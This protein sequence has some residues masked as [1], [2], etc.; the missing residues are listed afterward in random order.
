MTPLVCDPGAAWHYGSGIDWAGLMIEAV[1]GTTLDKYLA[2]NVLDP[3]SMRDTRYEPTPAMNARLAGVS[4]RDADGTLSTLPFQSPPTPEI[5]NGGHGLISTAADYAR[6]LQ[7]LLNRGALAG[8]RVLAAKTVDLMGE[9]HIG[10]LLVTRLETIAPR[11]TLDAEFLPGMQK[12]H[13]LAYMLSCEQWPNRRAI[14]SGFWAG[15]LNTFFWIDPINGIGGLLMLQ[16]LPFADGRVMAL[17]DSFE[18]AVYST[19]SR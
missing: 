3:L 14:G 7:M 13:G 18:E 10:D 11:L 6:F 8:T 2:E 16:Q 17:L 12:K 5:W 4:A 19:L 15:L 9:N 1:S